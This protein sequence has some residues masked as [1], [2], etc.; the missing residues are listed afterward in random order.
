LTNTLSKEIKAGIIRLQQ[1]SLG[2]K[3]NFI[4]RQKKK[5]KAQVHVESKQAEKEVMDD[6][7]IKGIGN[8]VLRPWYI[9]AALDSDVFKSKEEK[10]N[11]FLKELKVH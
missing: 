3:G 1:G 7:E 10:H 5:P 6:M 9:E 8:K 2:N 4:S 11:Y